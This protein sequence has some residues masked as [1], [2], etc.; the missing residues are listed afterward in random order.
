[1]PP[2]ATSASEPMYSRL[3]NDQVKTQNHASQ[4]H[5]LRDEPPSWDTTARCTSKPFPIHRSQQGRYTTAHR[6]LV[7]K[8]PITFHDFSP[9]DTHACITASS[10]LQASTMFPRVKLT[11][12]GRQVRDRQAENDAPNPFLARKQHNTSTWSDQRLIFTA[13]QRWL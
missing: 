11:A 9:R 12:E 1:M 5:K 2:T 7:P 3:R 10:R 13:L 4:G 8:L 6:T